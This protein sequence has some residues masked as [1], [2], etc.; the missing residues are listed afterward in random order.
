MD[1]NYREATDGDYEAIEELSKKIYGNTDTLVHSFIDFLNSDEWFLFVGEVNQ[2]KVIA[3]SAVHVTDGTESLNIR[4]SRVD[5]EYRG[6]GVYKGLLNYAVRYVKEK[7]LDIKYL[8]RLRAADVRVP[9]GYEI[10]KKVGLM[11]MF[12]QFDNKI[13]DVEIGAT[14]S[15]VQVMKWP[16]FKVLYDGNETVKDLFINAILQVHCDLFSLNCTANW[17]LL[18]GRLD[19]RIMLSEYEGEDGKTELTMSFLRLGKFFTNNGVPMAALNVYGLNK[20]GLHYHMRKRALEASEYFG[21]ERFLVVVWVGQGMLPE[22]VN[23][24]KEIAGSDVDHWVDLNLLIG[25]LSKN[26][27]DVQID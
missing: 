1:V 6:R 25:D 23:I 21:G 22:C 14:Q 16:D 12:L 7:L 4:S 3:F 9:D 18:Q 5:K 17:R 27:E 24:A 11:K 10:M 8:Y 26:L 15:N 2:R 13:G 20:S 19:T